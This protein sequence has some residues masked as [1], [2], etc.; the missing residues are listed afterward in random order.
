MESAFPAGRSRGVTVA[1][2]GSCLAALIAGA[3]MVGSS[4]RPGPPLGPGV[5][6]GHFARI[7]RAMAAWWCRLVNRSTQRA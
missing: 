4:A 2:E 1:I 5:I 7:T 3:G 6:M